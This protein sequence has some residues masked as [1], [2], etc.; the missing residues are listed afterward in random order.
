MYT[1]THTHTHALEKNL[2]TESSRGIWTEEIFDCSIPVYLFF[3]YYSVRFS[4]EVRFG[5]D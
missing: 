4:L 2:I 3:M 1:H 5:N